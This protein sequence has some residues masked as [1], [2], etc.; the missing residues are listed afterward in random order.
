MTIS[1]RGIGPLGT[2]GAGRS[3]LAAA[4]NLNGTSQVPQ[5]SPKVFKTE[6]S[7]LSGF[8]PAKKMRRLDHYANMVL[9][10]AGLALEDAGLTGEEKKQTGIILSTGHGPIET[11]FSFLES[12]LD[13]GDALSKPTRFSTSVHTFAASSL[14]LIFG[15]DGPVLNV[16][17]FNLPFVSA[18]IT[19]V[20][21]LKEKRVS[22]VL[23]GGVDELSNA[24][25][26]A[27]PCPMP[28]EGG[29]FFVL[30]HDSGSAVHLAHADIFMPGATDLSFLK[31]GCLIGR[32]Q[33]RDRLGGITSHA[34]LTHET[35]YGSF[36]SATALDLACAMI[37]QAR[38]NAAEAHT[39]DTCRQFGA[40]R[41]GRLW[42]ALM[43]A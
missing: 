28:G 15:I 34:V 32:E 26:Y 40:I 37:F 21:W 24:A 35:I 16:A 3:N 17:D 19:A 43:L 4:L 1:I 14:S 18:I 10:S 7:A 30:S 2:F 38:S 33:D 20:T 22:H 27:A 25:M 31:A 11:G 41:T 6:T 42:G 9:L 39:P 36:P 12:F 29:C 13:K 23:V 8:I 5:N